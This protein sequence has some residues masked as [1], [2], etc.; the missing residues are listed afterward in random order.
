MKVKRPLPPKSQVSTAKASP[1]SFKEEIQNWA[2]SRKSA[3]DILTDPVYKPFKPTRTYSENE[4]KSPKEVDKKK[5]AQVPTKMSTK[6]WNRQ[7][8]QAVVPAPT[9]KY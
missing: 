3:V 1:L 2:P 6:F 4:S 5:V 7:K 9:R 8:S